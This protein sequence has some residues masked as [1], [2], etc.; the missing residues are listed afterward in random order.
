M[1]I[2]TKYIRSISHFSLHHLIVVDVGAIRIIGHMYC[3][4]IDFLFS[5]SIPLFHIQQPKQRAKKESFLLLMLLYVH[6][7][8]VLH[9]NIDFDL[10]SCFARNRNFFFVYL[11]TWREDMHTHQIQNDTRENTYNIHIY[12]KNK[13]NRRT[14]RKMKFLFIKIFT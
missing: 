13:W 7:L 14:G 4:W 12:M 5:L 11:E 10:L 1:Q 2:Q 3:A 9:L 8:L 6:L